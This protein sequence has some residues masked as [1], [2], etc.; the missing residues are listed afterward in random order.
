MFGSGCTNQPAPVLPDVAVDAEEKDSLLYELPASQYHFEEGVFKAGEVLGGVLNRLGLSPEAAHRI[1]SH[2]HERFDTR[3]IRPG[4]KYVLATHKD[5]T[6]GSRYFIYEPH[7][8]HFWLFDVEGPEAPR[9]VE[10]PLQYRYEKLEGEIA[11]SFYV[12]ATEAG[13]GVAMTHNL[14]RIFD[15]TV[16]FLRMNKGDAFAVYY[17]AA[18]IGTMRLDG[19]EEILSARFTQGD[20]RYDCV[21]FEEGDVQGYYTPEGESMRRAFLKAPLEYS[22]ISSRFSKRRFH[23]VQKRF[24]AHLGT[25]YA[26]PTGTPIR[27]TGNGIVIESKYGKFNGHYVKIKH[28]AT[29]TTQYLHMSKRLVQKGDRVAQGDVI[30]LVGSTGLA[31]GPHVCYRFWKNG[32]QVDALRE[33]PPGG[34]PL[35]ENL[36]AGFKAHADSLL[37]PLGQPS[38]L[39]GL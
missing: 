27:A 38:A 24:K 9:L 31:S 25:D 33:T 20:K 35:P 22:R 10:R 4:E 36:L 8:T 32:V 37:K 23:P 16:D 26:A 14:S 5:T 12:A 6:I 21:Y 34:D 18:Y 2:Q 17:K 1:A 11:S 28:N 30:G 15:W 13:M 7:I 3:R 19:R 29:Y 39:A